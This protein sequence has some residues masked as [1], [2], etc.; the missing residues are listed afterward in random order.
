VPTDL[1]P[2]VVEPAPPNSVSCSHVGCN[3]GQTPV[4]VELLRQVSP[5]SSEASEVIF[6]CPG[7]GNT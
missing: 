6:F 1:V 2:N 4:L 7:R 3:D 5:L